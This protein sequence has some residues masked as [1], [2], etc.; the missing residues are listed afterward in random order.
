MRL[1]F[2]LPIVYATAV[3]ET[4]LA[5]AIRVGHVTPDLLALLAVTWLLVARG[6]GAF[7]IAGVIGLAADLISPGRLGLGMASFL[8]VGYGLARLRAKFELDHLLWQVPAV[9]AATTVLAVSLATG[10]WLLGEA[11]APLSTLLVRAVGVGVYTAGVSLPLLMII[12]WFRE[13]FRAREK[14]LAGF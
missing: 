4:S 11:A 2:L 9:C 12:G 14:R 3:L 6:R 5:D 13:P 1:L 7:L 10:R 8:L